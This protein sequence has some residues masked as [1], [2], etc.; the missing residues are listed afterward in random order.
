MLQKRTVI[1]VFVGMLFFYLF[2]PAIEKVYRHMLNNT[3]G[4][5][6]EDTRVTEDL[7]FETEMNAPLKKLN[8]KD[9]ETLT[10][11][12]K[13]KSGFDKEVII[14]LPKKVKLNITLTKQQN[15]EN[16]VDIQYQEA[17]N[18]VLLNWKENTTQMREI[19]LSIDIDDTFTAGEDS[20]FAMQSIDKGIMQ[21]EHIPLE[22]E[23]QQTKT[24][25]ETTKTEPE[26]QEESEKVKTEPEKQVTTSSPKVTSKA[27]T[28]QKAVTASTKDLGIAPPSSDIDITKSFNVISGAN[29][30]VH[31]TYPSEVVV[32]DDEKW[33]Y[34]GAWYKYPLNLS[35]DFSTEMYYYLGDKSLSEGGA[36]GLTFTFHNDPRGLEATGANGSGLGA[37]G[38]IATKSYIKNA[39]TLEFDTYYNAKGGAETGTND[40]QVPEVAKENGHIAI[41]QPAL[42]VKKHENLLYGSRLAN[43]KWQKLTMRWDAASQTFI[44]KF[45]DYPEQTY[46][47]SD[48]QKVFGGTQIYWGFT[49]STGG[50]H[51]YQAVSINKLPD[52]GFLN[53]SKKVKNITKNTT[54]QE[55]QL[56]SKGD[57]VEYE[58]SAEADQ[59]NNVTLPAVKVTDNLADKLIYRGNLNVKVNNKNVAAKWEDGIISLENIEAG[60]KIAITFQAEVK[61]YGVINNS[62]T[63]ESELTA[64]IKTNNTKLSSGD[65][66]IIKQDAV[67]K[68]R[69]EGVI[70]ALFNS[71]NVK[72]KEEKTNENGEILFSH[73]SHGEYSV[74][75]VE[76]L[77]G[78]TIDKNSHKCNVVEGQKE[79]IT[80]V[81]NNVLQS[82][83]TLTK[84]VDK[85]QAKVGDI[86]TYTLE[87]KNEENAGSWENV[88]LQDSLPEELI[89]VNNSTHIDGESVKDSEAIW[90]KNQLTYKKDHIS[91][92]EVKQITFQ[93]KVKTMPTEG[94]LKNTATATG[95]DTDG[96]IRNPK[97]VHSETTIK[98]HDDMSIE[99]E[100]QTLAGETLEGQQVTVGS[101]IKYQIKLIN[102]VA[103]TALKNI[104]VKDIVSNSLKVDGTSLKVKS[105]ESGESNVTYQGG[106]K[107][108]ELKM[109][110]KEL[111]YG[112]PITISFEATVQENASGI[113]K[114]IAIAQ[115]PDTPEKNAE[116]STDIPPR[117]AIHKEVNELAAKIGDKLTYK[118]SVENQAGGGIWYSPI[119]QDVL[120]DGLQYQKGTTTI[121]GKTI[122]DDKVW[123]NN[124][125]QLELSQLKTNEKQEICFETKVIKNTADQ[126]I[127]NLVEANGKDGDGK[128][129]ETVKAEAETKVSNNPN[130]VMI[131]KQVSD[132]VGGNLEQQSVRTGDR[133]YYSLLV[134]NQIADSIQENIKVKDSLPKGLQADTST[135]TVMQGNEKIAY[136][137]GFQANKLDL[138]ITS[139]QGEMP[140]IIRFAT[141]ITPEASGKIKNIA[142]IEIDG[143]PDKES[144][145]N[146]VLNPPKPIIE[147]SAS[148]DSAKLGEVFDYEIM[149][150]NETGGG[151]WQEIMVKDKLPTYLEYVSG[152]TTINGAKTDDENWKTN[153]YND[154]VDKLAANES[155]LLHFKV[156]VIEIPESRELINISTATGIDKDG[157]EISPI[158]AK[159]IVKVSYDN[160]DI[161]ITKDIITKQGNILDHPVVEVGDKVYY[162]LQVKNMVHQSV[163]KEVK[164]TDDVSQTLEIDKTSLR[165]EAAGKEVS[166]Q[167]G[168]TGNHLNL[169]QLVVAADQPI[170]IIFA[171]TVNQE[172][173][174]FVGNLAHVNL[175]EQSVKDSNEVTMSVLPK[176]FL[177]KR[178]DKKSVQLGDRITYTLTIQNQEKGGKWFLPAITDKLSPYLEYQSGTLI[179]D[180]K[181]VLDEKG[182]WENNCLTISWPEMKQGEIHT[183]IFQAKNIATP[184]NKVIEN[185]VQGSGQ[186]AN[187]KKYEPEEAKTIVD[188]KDNADALRIK[189]QVINEKGEQ[190]NTEKVAVGDRLQY[191][192]KVENQIAGTKLSYVEIEDLVPEAF[193]VV[194]GS[195][196]VSSAAYQGGFNDQMLT[197]VIDELAA[198]KPITIQFD[199][200]VTSEASGIVENQ[201]IAGLS[202]E[203]KSMSNKVSN[204]VEPIPKVIKTVN[205]ENAT[206]G[207][208]V[209]YTVI[210]ENDPTGG[211]WLNVSIEDTLEKELKYIKGSTEIDGKIVNEAE[212]AELWQGNK[213][214][215]SFSAISAGEKHKI[216]FKAKIR[217]LPSNRIIQNIAT[218]KGQ[219]GDGKA[220]TTDEAIC[221]LPVANP[222]NAFTISKRVLNGEQVDINQQEVQVGE[223]IYYQIRVENELED[224]VLHDLQIQDDVTSHFEVVPAS[225]TVKQENGDNIIYQGGFTSQKLD[226]HLDTVTSGNPVIITFG[227]KVQS[228][229][230]GSIS[231]TAHAI[232]E[233]GIVHDTLPVNNSIPPKPLITQTADVE[234][235]K[236]GDTFTYTIEVSNQGKAGKWLNSVLK[237]ELDE[238]LDYIPG[239]TTLNGQ[240][241]SDQ[242]A[243]F[244]E[245][246]QLQVSLED[247]Q[248]EEKQI[249]TIKV[250]VNAMPKTNALQTFAVSSGQDGDG[251]AV[252]TEKVKTITPVTN[253]KDAIRL[254]KKVLDKDNKNI[255]GKEVHVGDRLRYAIKVTNL[256][257]NTTLHDVIVTDDLPEGVTYIPGTLQ[258]CDAEEQTLT[259]EKDIMNNRLEAKIGTI[260]QQA[261]MQFDVVV[262]KMAAGDIKNVAFGSLADVPPTPSQPATNNANSHPTIEKSVMPKKVANNQVA[263]YTIKVKNQ[264]GSGIWS[265]PIIEDSLDKELQYVTNSTT[266]DGKKVSDQIA[267]WKNNK[268]TSKLEALAADETHI[269]RFQVKILAKKGTKRIK[270]IASF[271]NPTTGEKPNSNQASCHLEIKKKP[272]HFLLPQTGDKF[273]VIFILLGAIGIC[274]SGWWLRKVEKG[275]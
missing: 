117:P 90:N 94:I 219:D 132:E 100:V 257:E 76:S 4:M 248:A 143:V 152:T 24:Q 216:K 227:V 223:Q 57:I 204:F 111:A 191:K 118:I 37:Y 218:A 174:G 8:V 155:Y 67:T 138:R 5:A 258:V 260:K 38:N 187:G 244:Q 156:R 205:Q 153:Q 47:V 120:S 80:Q 45:A 112:S 242:Q 97:E 77:S 1:V 160:K 59:K 51:N 206:L 166:Y 261:T 22:I 189:K 44:Y 243:G 115:I 251:I 17:A 235:T 31:K 123:K 89:L 142:T 135:L 215:T 170:T 252:N 133:I 210:V 150:K 264:Q 128:R 136:T 86:L 36:D 182:Y 92:G 63:I 107:D 32:T 10:I 52:Q 229:A 268:L 105:G 184:A 139:L 239:S 146:E 163:L 125:F 14:Y 43:G 231:N 202:T 168:F 169:E 145:S 81:V 130:G 72:L 198:D 2:Q 96:T 171:V 262:N 225:L 88:Q 179:I 208:I 176:P 103:G 256:L 9:K 25:E 87:L 221:E 240:T 83:P 263:T 64:P 35:A 246:G 161:A 84:K 154:I 66:K 212:D 137:G 55:N 101:K 149:V 113:I 19:I 180:G 195:L 214:K 209:E 46:K 58:I 222:D 194:P 48:L 147:K 141:T 238:C 254:D 12:F 237:G 50:K 185:T 157:L 226:L 199:V 273:M 124:K 53:T 266:I 126:K 85:S 207:D 131:E 148:V 7:F 71:E 188:A 79:P 82:A 178:A 253:P 186:D 232:L 275:N 42:A 27:A 20:L 213:F 68:K 99:K 228:T 140:A 127:K 41:V 74:K 122:S 250:H 29:S 167:G 3:T 177:E 21:S 271:T 98:N 197:L 162:R 73:L 234:Q 108:N 151:V 54:F 56:V 272:R 201:G 70:F 164:V 106:F 265:Q 158:P 175:P 190:I 159:N 203:T 217:E 18:K 114:N 224:T 93:A 230:T 172:A 6:I 267:G 65:I 247:L 181:E 220:I 119:I 11:K 78:Y 173:S 23:K 233:N 211:K 129:T 116:T 183:I 165:V 245:T 69:L 134:T 40:E 33:Q 15:N 193:K 200:I 104:T 259:Y 241:I 75:E 255:Q 192:L 102:K 26:K 60:S 30:Y 144:N 34:G 16:M 13:Q 274:I 39:I 49:G 61:D 269:I 121:N 270:N 28:E 249:I 196:E 62:A 109:Q 95:K 110:V 91:N 236:V